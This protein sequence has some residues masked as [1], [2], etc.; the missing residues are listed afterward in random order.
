MIVPLASA[1]TSLNPDRGWT[2]IRR[3]A[4]G[5]AVRGTSVALSQDGNIALVGKMTTGGLGAK[6]SLPTYIGNH[7]GRKATGSAHNAGVAVAGQCD[8]DALKGVSTRASAD[9]LAAL[10]GPELTFPRVDPR[11]SDGRIAHQA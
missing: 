4:V 7:Q 3:D 1:E 9:Q 2:T 8:K 6:T 11:T 5:N 10:L